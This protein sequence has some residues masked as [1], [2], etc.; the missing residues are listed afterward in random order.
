MAHGAPPG[1]PVGAF[2]RDRRGLYLAGV[3]RDIR[4]GICG[5]STPGHG[6]ESIVLSGGCEDDVDLGALIYYTGQGG[7]DKSGVQTSNQQLAGLNAG[8][9]KN[10]DS[11]EPVRVTRSTPGG[12]R[13]DGLYVV[14]DAWVT[15]G[16]SGFLVC[17]YRLR[18]E[19]FSGDSHDPTS[20]PGDAPDPQDIGVKAPAP[21]R[22]GTHYRLVRD[23]GLPA[24]VKQ[25]YDY[26]CQICGTRVETAA[27]PYAE[28]AHLVPLGGA[29]DGHDHI[30][31]LLCLCPND[32]VRLDHG[33][34]GLTD[35]WKVI[36][37][38][39]ALLGQ[40]SFKA[41]HG[42]EVANARK[43]REFFDIPADALAANGVVVRGSQQA[44]ASESSA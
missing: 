21:R 4:R 12:F 2:F 19:T 29:Q 24:Q 9:A 32:H 36:S 27:G 26:V 23:G 34:L 16:K 31:N 10:V 18:S 43:H 17:R 39:G 11:L 44:H 1:V 37:R 14:E 25:L 42:L 33:Y 40:L 22:Q 7:R 41:E 35:D 38:H 13:Y 6:A 8:L 28:G 30:S 20:Q 5:S 15:A 3:H